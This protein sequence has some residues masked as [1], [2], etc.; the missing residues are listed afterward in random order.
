[1]LVPTRSGAG[2]GQGGFPGGSRRAPAS[3][4]QARP[5]PLGPPSLLPAH[6]AP[7]PRPRGCGFCSG[8]GGGGGGSGHGGRRRGRRGSR[9]LE[10]PRPRSEPP[11]PHFPT[12]H[13]PLPPLVLLPPDPQVL[14]VLSRPPPPWHPPETSLHLWTWGVPSLAVTPQALPPRLSSP[15]VLPA[16]EGRR[17]RG[18]GPFSAC[19]LTIHKSS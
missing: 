13:L 10:L 1:M 7:G 15:T 6:R 14:R 8:G 4:G 11:L 5:R 3:G 12:L 17:E 16:R 19:T 18:G 9:G 2:D